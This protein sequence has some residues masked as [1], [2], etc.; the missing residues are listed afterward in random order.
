[1]N[2]SAVAAE[3]A[4]IQT[5]EKVEQRYVAFCD[6]LGFSAK[7]ANDY[8]GT[9]DVYRRFAERLDPELFRSEVKITMYSDAILLTS[10][11][12]RPLLTTLQ[13]LWFTALSEDLMLRGGV[14]YGRYWER[15]HG[16]HLM[17]VSDALVAAVK[18][19]GMIG[20]PAIALADDIEIP[21]DFWVARFAHG[22]YAVSLVHFRDRNIVNPFTPFWGTSAA[23]R[24][25]QLMEKSPAHK[26][27]YLWFLALYEA[28]SS[29]ATLVPDH[30]F[31]EMIDK[32]IIKWTPPNSDTETATDESR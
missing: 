32:G 28:V 29:N 7:L 27:K 17:V 21:L 2:Q 12:L 8:E 25:R 18:I 31:R 22:P 14:S 9:L 23:Q 26:Q 3:P 1:M 13:V 5:E 4:Q 30:A 6:I 20:V 15:R 19:E 11:E 24:C 16:D 10:R